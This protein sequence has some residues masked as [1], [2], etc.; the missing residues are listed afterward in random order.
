MSDSALTGGF[1]C[2]L[3]YI[4]PDLF[5]DKKGGSFHSPLLLIVVPN[6]VPHFGIV[7][8][9]QLHF[10]EDSLPCE[11]TTV[12]GTEVPTP[13]VPPLAILGWAILRQ[14]LASGVAVGLY[15]GAPYKNVG[16]IC[17]LTLLLYLL[18][19]T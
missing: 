8:P 1:L 3:R 9:N 4:I 11:K 19:I 18:K 12:H 10:S 7:I 15:F 14:P 17:L 6:V 5:L 13:P 2:L 16:H